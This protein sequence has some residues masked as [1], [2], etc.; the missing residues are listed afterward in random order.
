MDFHVLGSVLHRKHVMTNP[1]NNNVID[2]LQLLSTER[3]RIQADI[4]LPYR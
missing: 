2:Y 1:Y 3:T 4:V